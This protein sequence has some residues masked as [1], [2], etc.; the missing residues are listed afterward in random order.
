MTRDQ[1]FQEQVAPRRV[2]AVLR[3]TMVL[4]E[5]VRREE[6][7]LVRLRGCVVELE[8]IHRA[9]SVLGDRT[10]SEVAEANHRLTHADVDGAA[11]G[12][13]GR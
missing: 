5:L 11:A 12:G 4:L 6:Q 13:R 10:E 2:D 9:R 3:D 1:R 8:A 7:V